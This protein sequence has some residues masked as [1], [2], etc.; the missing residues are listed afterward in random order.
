MDHESDAQ[1]RQGMSATHQHLSK[2]LLEAATLNAERSEDAAR[3]SK[4]PYVEN[5]LEARRARFHGQAALALTQA[6]M[7]ST[8]ENER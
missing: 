4:N 5:D 2:A 3:D 6:W 1:E 8:K 7:T